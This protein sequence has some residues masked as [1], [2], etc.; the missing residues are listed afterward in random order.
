MRL[1]DDAEVLK[2]KNRAF[3]FELVTNNPRLSIREIAHRIGIAYTTAKH[4]I[5]RLEKQEFVEK[6]GRYWWIKQKQNRP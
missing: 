5:L 6:N 3:V 2:N 4:H 1:I